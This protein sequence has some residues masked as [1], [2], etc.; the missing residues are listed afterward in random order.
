MLTRQNRTI[1]CLFVSFSKCSDILSRLVTL[2]SNILILG[3]TVSILETF[4]L[5]REL[6]VHLIHETTAT[7][8][9]IIETWGTLEK[10]SIAK[11]R[12]LVLS[13][14]AWESSR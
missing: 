5:E 9:M 7:F 1:D 13:I 8:V 2:L 6:V 14:L 4:S 10:L 3:K 11:L 12:I